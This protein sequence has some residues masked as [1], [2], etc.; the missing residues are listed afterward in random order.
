MEDILIGFVGQ[1]WIGKNYA[2]DFE[3][4][5]FSVIRYSLEE[6]YVANKERIKDCDMV[7]IAVPTPRHLRVSMIRSSGR[8]FPWLAMASQP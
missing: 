8:Q 5:G 6:P 2:D 1:G 4:R 7:F 3:E